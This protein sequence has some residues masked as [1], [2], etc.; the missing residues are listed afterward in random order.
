[1]WPY[2]VV[3]A[4]LALGALTPGR[5]RGQVERPHLLIFPTVFLVLFVGLRVQVGG[6]WYVYLRMF[7][8][9]ASVDI[10][11]VLD[12]SITDPAYGLVNW[13]VGQRHAGISDIWAVN[14]ICAIIFA[15]GLRSFCR[16]QTNPP[17]ALLVA[18]PYLVVVVAMGY[19]RQSVALGLIMAA[20]VQYQRG[21]TI[22]M[23]LLL[24]LATAF[25]KSAAIVI[26]FF[27]VAEA[28]G[29]LTSLVVVVATSALSY[30]VF[31]QNNVNGLIE[32]YIGAQYNSSGAGIR[33]GMNLLAAAIFFVYR[34]KIP[35]RDREY[36][37]WFVFA[38]A[39]IAASI[40]YVYSPS[41]TA[42]DRVALYLLP[43]QVTML[44]R[45]PDIYHRDSQTRL[46]LIVLV[47]LYSFI[48]GATWLLYAKTSF[49][50][51]PYRNFLW[52]PA[53]FQMGYHPR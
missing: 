38:L 25:H 41:S 51:V 35:F 17:L 32:N 36:R 21:R 14:L 23:V 49:A 47:V 46:F 26:P 2:A 22:N 1:M 30:Y 5:L 28:K 15:I 34:H 8:R 11:S 9:C 37:L 53:H 29:K 6:D 20:I 13:I 24:V 10:W 3:F 50:W 19:E 12:G 43:I 27:A 52:L 42:V 48:V 33:I 45:L 44:S 40:A 31:L 18:F 4:F 39:V 16:M 7:L